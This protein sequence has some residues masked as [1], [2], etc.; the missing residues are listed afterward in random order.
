MENERELLASTPTIRRR[1]RGI[2]PW[3]ADHPDALRFVDLWI[4]MVEKG[5]SDWTGP[6]LHSQLKARFGFTYTCSGPFYAWMR[7]RREIVLG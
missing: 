4:E 6:E 7:E 1:P 3:L 5:E 2:G